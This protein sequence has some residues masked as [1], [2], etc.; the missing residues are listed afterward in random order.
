MTKSAALV[1]AILIVCVS[2]T[3]AADREFEIVNSSKEIFYHLY[4][5]PTDTSQWG[6]DQLGE[7][8]EDALEPGAWIKV[9]NLQPGTY[10][11]KIVNAD[12]TSCV[13]HR[14]ML[15]FDK[16]VTVTNQL[17]ETCRQ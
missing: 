1:G 14:V 16:I 12:E 5:A 15:E 9:R 10:D 11:L 6:S 3:E 8:E 4:F 17:L 13:I 2:S 7:D